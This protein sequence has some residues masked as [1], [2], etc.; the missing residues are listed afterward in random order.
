MQFISRFATLASLFIFHSLAWSAPS[1][2]VF[3]FN[4]GGEP[5]SLAPSQLTTTDASSL[6][7]NLYRGLYWYSNEKGLQ[8]EG[9][10]SC[11]WSK[12]EL[13]L[14]CKLKKNSLWSDG[15]SIEAA[16]YV[17][18]WRE[19]FDTAAKTAGS[20]LL[21]SLKNA[22]E[23]LKRQKHKQDL[24]VEAVDP[25]TL[26]ISFAQKDPEFL[27]KLVLAPLAPIRNEKFVSREKASELLTNGPYKISEW[28]IGTRVILTPNANFHPESAGQR[29]RV[30]ILFIEEDLT[31]LNLYESGEITLLRR[32]P[33]QYYSRFNKTKEFKEIPF[34]RFDYIGFGAKLQ[35]KPH[36]RKALSLAADYKELQK[37]Y[38]SPGLPG[39]PS[40]TDRMFAKVPC[41]KFDLAEAKKE[42]ELAKKTENVPD[43]LEFN[44]SKL[45]ADLIQQG[46]EWYQAQWKKN[47]GI[48]VDLKAIERSILMH[49]LKTNAPD[50]FRKS[51]G[52]NRPTCLAAVEDFVSQGDENFTK[53]QDPEFDKIVADLSKA[54]S[55]SAKKKLCSKAVERLMTES[56]I[57]P[58]GMFFNVFLARPSFS[59][60]TVNELNQLDLTNL[61]AQP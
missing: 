49:S 14:T 15:K 9:A 31:A 51:L 16:D 37:I 19:L 57:I 11:S 39:C 24:G 8:P 7:S 54:K 40:L 2:A 45:S 41:V 34:L 44:Y 35:N 42:F 59:G 17:R 25:Q 52:V 23:I 46:M 1:T 3:R 38:Q 6:F 12:D 61:K 28:K 32:V 60:W 10:E 43:R 5:H 50:I 21:I 29:P 22:R 55:E 56:R 47:L 4:I 27:F 18:A 58:Q 36:L 48:K 33:P 53:V 13:T 26:K 30:E 20:E